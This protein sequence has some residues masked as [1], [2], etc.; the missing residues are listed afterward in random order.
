MSDPK[1]QQERES[2]EL[3]LEAE[4]VK[5]LDLV[6]EEAGQLGAMRVRKGQLD[7]TPVIVHSAL[8]AADQAG[9]RSRGLAP[10]GDDA[11]TDSA[12]GEGSVRRPRSQP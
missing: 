5:D 11:E 6:E 9:T 12:A 8:R 1:E 4:T 10:R 7:I 2:D 3:E